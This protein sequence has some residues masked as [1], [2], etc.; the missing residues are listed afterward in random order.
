MITTSN[1]V[2]NKI[3]EIV[4]KNYIYLNIISLILAI[5]IIFF[6]LISDLITPI[7]PNL[8]ECAYLK[9]TGKPCPLCGGTRYIKSFNNVFKDIT[10]LFNPF[11]FIVIFVLLEILFRA[12]NLIT[13]KKDKSAKYIDIDITIHLIVLNIF[14]I[15]EC[16]F[17]ILQNM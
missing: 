5:Y 14:F 13:I 9:A 15:Y 2:E 16:I 12:Y 10:Y 17:L 4:K 1:T 11:G 3:L 6:P 8:F 7:F